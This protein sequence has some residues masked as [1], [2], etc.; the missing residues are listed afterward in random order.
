[1]RV[2]WVDAAKGIAIVLVVQFHAYFIL[3]DAGLPTTF[4]RI[5]GLLVPFRMPLFFFTAG[6]F[7]LGA[8]RMP[9]TRLLKSRVIRLVWLYIL[10]I[11][12]W[13]VASVVFPAEFGAQ[14]N[15]S[16]I[17]LASMMIRPHSSL[18]FLYALAI[19]FIA[20]WLVLRIPTSLQL[21]VTLTPA[22]LF[23]AAIIDTGS[24]PLNKIGSYFIWF[25][26][27]ARFGP[28]LMVLVIHAKWWQVPMWAVGF[29][30]A[31]L[32]WASG[33]RWLPG[34]GLTTSA[35][36][37]AFGA[38]LSA[39]L[40]RLRAFDWLPALGKRTL[41]I[42]VAHYY[43]M[44]GV[45]TAMSALVEPSKVSSIIWVLVLTG[46]GVAFPPLVQRATYRALPWLWD[47]P[48][49]GTRANRAFRS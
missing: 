13:V 49:P 1:M 14:E 25:F 28:S 35:L 34:F 32:I 36:A 39:Q 24:D 31:A 8:L 45:F 11:S 4:G 22:I 48:F 47:S 44:V 37:I 7:A 26:L 15:N 12:I 18:W 6:L 19:Y 3:A 9:L 10:W 33:L 43:I 21:A 2:E 42:Y 30:L 16:I 38:T 27:A 46:V 23:G 17:S 40:V 41:A 29:G 5:A 20:G